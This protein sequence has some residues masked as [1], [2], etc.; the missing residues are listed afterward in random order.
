M[1]NYYKPIHYSREDKIVILGFNEYENAPFNVHPNDIELVAGDKEAFD[2]ID[3]EKIRVSEWTI[4]TKKAEVIKWIF[5]QH[6]K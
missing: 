2:K 1:Y 4:I 3:K 6:F 5:D